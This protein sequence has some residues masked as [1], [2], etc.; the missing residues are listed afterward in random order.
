MSRP[1]PYRVLMTA[2][3]VGG[4][5]TFAME[6]CAA[7]A[8]H[9]V[10][11]TLFTM[12]RPPDE[13]QRAQARAWP[14]VRLVSTG[15]RLEWMQDCQSDVVESG[16]ALLQLARELRPDIV[17]VNGY[18]HA[19][20]PFDAPVLLT[21]HSCVASWWHACRRD[22]IPIEWWRY[23]NWISAGLR[24]ADMLT[25]PTHSF[26]NEFQTLHGKAK[27]ARAI[28]NG[29]DSSGFHPGPKKNMVLAAGRLWDEAKNIGL[30]C[31]IAADLKAPLVVAGDDV[32][33][34]G[35]T[36]NVSD[37]E[38]LGLLEHRALAARMGNAAVFASPARYEP[39]GLTILEAALS[40]CALVLSDIPSLR[41][42]WDGVATFVPAEDGKGWVDGL[43]ALLE[44][45]SLAAKGAQARERAQQ[46]SA[47]K[48][49]DSYFHTYQELLAKRTPALVEAAA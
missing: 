30:L 37:A 29:R 21:A 7:L 27:V 43:N 9:G 45:P 49:A 19:A 12:G 38:F 5:W 11:V 3:T 41:E 39:F 28:W 15:Y 23:L 1:A 6:L 44:Q 34:D 14:N 8:T 17:H 10:E 35:K 42:L 25:A 48:M 4:V 22:P 47:A 31:R 46:Y 16:K 36:V 13:A 18:Y 24:T 2:D 20:L 33:P 26:L 32:S 40:G